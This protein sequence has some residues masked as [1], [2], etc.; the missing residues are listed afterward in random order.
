MDISDPP[1]MPAPRIHALRRKQGR[2]GRGVKFGE[3]SLVRI[4]R[5]RRVRAERYIKDRRVVWQART[6]AQGLLKGQIVQPD[7]CQPV[8]KSPERTLEL[9]MPELADLSGPHHHE[10]LP[11]LGQQ[12][13]DA[14]DDARIV[15]GDRDS[16]LVLPKRSVA[17]IPL[18]D[19]REQE[20]RVGK[21]LLPILARE[22]CGGA[23]DRHDQVGL[24][25]I[26]EDGSDVV[27][28]RLFGRGDKPCRTHHDLDDVHRRFGTLVQF[29]AEVAGELVHRQVA[30]VERLQQQDLA[31]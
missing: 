16:G 25:M 7:K 27:D 29:D 14:I 4:R 11:G 22:D 12:L 9:A 19:G 21:K 26:D 24:G 23:G 2:I 18:V 1:T 30:A 10:H 31:R 3:H 6:A 17:E 8:V 20:R 13:Q 15:G 28:D 5:P